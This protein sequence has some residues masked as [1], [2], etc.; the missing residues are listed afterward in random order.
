MSGAG[1]QILTAVAAAAAATLVTGLLTHYLTKAATIESVANGTTPLPQGATPKT[2]DVTPQG[3]TP[4]PQP[5]PETPTNAQLAALAAAANTGE[6]G[7]IAASWKA[8]Q[9]Q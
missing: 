8:M 4:Q 3:S 1:Q 2:S 5:K 7:W 9:N 6:L